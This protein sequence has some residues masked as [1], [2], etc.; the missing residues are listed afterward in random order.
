MRTRLL[1]GFT[2]AVIGYIHGWIWGWSLFDPDSDLWA[3]AAAVLA[4]FGLAH[5]LTRHFRLVARPLIAATISLYLAWVA[6]TWLWGDHPSVVRS[7]TLVGGTLVGGALGR[8]RSNAD[9]LPIPLLS[10][11][12]GGLFGGALIQVFV[13]GRMFGLVEINTVTNYAPAVMAGGIL[14][15]LDGRYLLAGPVRPAD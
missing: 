14:G 11:L 12:H 10:A 4:V 13:M 2:G 9:G 8:R 7:L 1:A 5:G 3:L 6:G 15:W